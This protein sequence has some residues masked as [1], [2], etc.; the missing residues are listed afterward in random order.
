V[1]RLS[2]TERRRTCLIDCSVLIS[3]GPDE[4][5]GLGFGKLYNLVTKVALSLHF[6]CD[7]IGD[8]L[9][10]RFTYL[11]GVSC[12]QDG[13]HNRPPQVGRFAIIGLLAI[14]SFRTDYLQIGSNCV[15]IMRLRRQH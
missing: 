12:T 5:V 7:K 13:L 15:S 10:P 11:A 3:W 14:L 2:C 4:V 9:L 1:R 6:T 8:V